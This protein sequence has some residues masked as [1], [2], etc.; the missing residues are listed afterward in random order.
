MC[1]NGKSFYTIPRN[2]L[3]LKIKTNLKQGRPK[4]QKQT[5][6]EKRPGTRKQNIYLYYVYLSTRRVNI[7]GI[8]SCKQVGSTP[9]I[10]DPF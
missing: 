5:K 10:T 4:N 2:S 7:F 1:R 9:H 3:R 6:K 8:K